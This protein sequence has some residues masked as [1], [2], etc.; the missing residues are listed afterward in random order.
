MRANLATPVSAIERRQTSGICGLF[1]KNYSWAQLHALYRLILPAA[2]P[3]FQPSVNICPTD[4]VDMVVA[5]A[6][7]RQLVSN[8]R[9]ALVSHWWRR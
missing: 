4:P 9:W 2:I 6:A 1:T 3:N 8:V 5:T 7:G